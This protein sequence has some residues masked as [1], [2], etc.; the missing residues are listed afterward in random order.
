MNKMNL[1]QKVSCVFLF[2]AL[3][4]ATASAQSRKTEVWDFGGVEDA[5]ENIHNNIS[6]D[7]IDKLE[8]LPA[9]GRFSDQGDVTFGSLTV[10]VVKNDR[11]YFDSKAGKSAGVQGYTGLDFGDGY[12]SNGIFYC[13]GTGGEGRRYLLLK[14]VQAGDI[15]TFYAGTSNTSSKNIHFANVV[16]GKDDKTGADTLVRTGIQ[17]EQAPVVQASQ[18]NP[19][20][21]SYIALASGIYKIFTDPDAGKPV[22]YRLVHTPGVAVSGTLASLPKG[23]ASLK[24]VCRE[25]NQEL[26][27]SVKGSAY[28]ANLASGFTYTAI[29]TG[30]KGYGIDA[31]SKSVKLADAKAGSNLAV[32]LTVA[33]QKTYKVSGKISGISDTYDASKLVVVMNPPEGSVFQPIECA[34]EGKGASLA[35]SGELEP[36]VKYTASLG[37]GDDYELTGDVSFES[38]TAVTKDIAAKEKQVYDVTGSFIGDT[39]SVPS[40]VTFTNMDDKYV[41]TGTIAGSAFS[42]KLRDGSYEVKA[43]TSSAKTSNHVVVS[44][45]NVNKN[46]NLVKNDKT[47]QPLPLKKDIY[48]GGKK[49][50]YATV[51][52]A[53]DAAAAMKPASEDQRVTI[54]IAPGVYREQITVTAPYVSFVNDTPEQEVKLTWYYGIAYKYYSSNIAGYYDSDLAHDKFTKNGAA[55]WGVATYI[56]PTAAYFR[57][58]GITFETSFSKYVTDEEIADGVE[59]D[60]SLPF[61]R[62]IDSDVTSKAATERATALCSE[63]DFC[64]YNNCRF[65]GSQDTLYTAG[66]TCQYFKKCYVEGQTDF[67]FG[68]G[69]AVFEDCEIN[70]CGYSDFPVSGYLTAARTA[71]NK[72]YLFYNCLVSLNQSRFT[73]MGCFGRPW[74]QEAKVAWI[75]TILGG[76]QTIHPNGWT[77]MSNNVPEKAGFREFNTTFGGKPVDVSQRVAG[78]VLS[79]AK[80]YTPA[81]F[82]GGWKPA[83]FKDSNAAE[84]A[85]PKFSKK[86]SFTTNDDI[87]TPYPGHTITLSYSLGKGD[88]S[89][90]S[91]IDWYREKDGKK[92]LVRTT[93]GFGDKT[94]LLTSADQNAKISATVTPRLRNG[95]EG[96]AVEVK[97][98]ATVKEGRAV[99]SKGAVGGVRAEDKVNIFLAGDSTVRDYSDKG[100]WS[101]GKTRDEGAWGEFLQSYFSDAVAVQNFANGGRS[102]RNF[103]NEGNLSKI[104]SLIKKGDYLFIQFGHNDANTRDPDRAVNLGEPDKNGIYPVT[105]AV[106]GATSAAYVSKYGPESYT[107][108]CGGTYKWFLKQY[109]DAARNAGATP[110]LVTPVSRLY[111]DANGKITPHHDAD[112][113]KV[114]TNSYVTAVRQL[115]KEEKVQLVDGFEITKSFYEQAYIDGGKSV[116]EPRALMSAGDS[117]HNNKLGG[118]ILAGLFANNIKKEIPELA[119]AVVEPAKVSGISSNGDIVFAV[120]SHSTFTCADKFW[121]AYAQN[122]IDGFKTK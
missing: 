87:N 36:S 90:T 16:P 38:T 17:D 31:A 65:I 107:E 109:I 59:P 6:I 48:V 21:Y 43:E 69:D 66:T 80:D 9:G 84:G 122:L 72:G 24:F 118:F 113:A 46:I 85:S 28:S 102:T 1:I 30:I 56:K 96:K 60:G 82:F 117:T 5:G 55:R 76:A 7:S 10:N 23:T 40:S 2:A 54:H 35:Y 15:V 68:D 111:F 53:V 97:L 106:K 100:M 108:T 63:A 52:A 41:Y 18:A 95:K 51:Q 12:T 45:K 47:V 20:R 92:E 88:E 8:I 112:D 105:P 27:A 3:S 94:Y 101:G 67:I 116:T 32:N 77:S 64:E 11:M 4:L 83:F 70:W 44:G 29:L 93:T 57:A 13:N 42:V 91:I 86:P 73:Q 14:D 119:G 114:K 37:G 75:N 99:A 103:I 71:S 98:A 74:G 78:T 104:A 34:T 39:S 58:D 33:E 115:A 110:V 19:G 22:F 49:P 89:D 79:D 81:S 120:D 61:T 25:T 121:T 62:R 50:D 26:P